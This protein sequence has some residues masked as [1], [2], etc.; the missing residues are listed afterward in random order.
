MTGQANKPGTLEC[1]Q[2]ARTANSSQCCPSSL[3]EANQ[4]LAQPRLEALQPERPQPTGPPH[5]SRSSGVC[6]QLP[7]MRSSRMRL[8]PNRRCRVVRIAAEWNMNQQQQLPT[9]GSSRMRLQRSTGRRET[10]SAGSQPA[11][12]AHSDVWQSAATES[13]GCEGNRRSHCTRG[14]APPITSNQHVSG[15][16]KQR[17]SQRTYSSCRPH[18]GT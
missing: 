7:T 17:A 16:T 2:Q 3:N 14:A 12:R 5:V 8:Q 15:E 18:G 11:S 6:R 4:G 9:I 1:L 13:R 10:R